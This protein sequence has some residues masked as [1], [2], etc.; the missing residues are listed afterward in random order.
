MVKASIR[1]ILPKTALLER[2]QPIEREPPGLRVEA[3]P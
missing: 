3:T 2:G 1:V